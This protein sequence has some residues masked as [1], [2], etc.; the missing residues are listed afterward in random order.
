MEFTLIPILKGLRIGKIFVQLCEAQEFILY[1]EVHSL[2][3]EVVRAEYN[4]PE[5]FETL[6]ED[7]EGFHLKQR[8]PLPRTLNRCVQ[9]VDCK[10]MKVRHKLI[11]HVQLHNPDGHLSELRASLPIYIFISPHLPLGEDNYIVDT[12]PNDP[13]TLEALGQHAP[14]LY[15]EHEFDLPYDHLDPNG[16]MTPVGS[17]GDANSPFH[18]QSRNLSSEDLNPTAAANTTL[19]LR[20]RLRN[21]PDASSSFWPSN[22]HSD[23]SSSPSQVRSDSALRMSTTHARDADQSSN[24]SSDGGSMRRRGSDVSQTNSSLLS[25]SLSRTNS[26]G[27]SSPRT[28]EHAE[29]DVNELSKVP[30]YTTALK[31]TVRTPLRDDLP[32]YISATRSSPPSPLSPPAAAAP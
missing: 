31:N 1:D 2:I 12:N 3:R 26:T 17:A 19:G 8:L 32:T 6:G 20:D 30:S 5:G 11:F 14:P 15:G 23:S 25:S 27:P 16:Y 29:M 13:H 24:N 7:Q 9:D 22:R 4:I 18:T 21:L 10:G 28:L